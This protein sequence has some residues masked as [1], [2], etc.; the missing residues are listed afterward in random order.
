MPGFAVLA[1]LDLR[2]LLA[3]ANDPF[4]IADGWRMNG[5]PRIGYRFDVGGEPVEAGLTVSDAAIGVSLGERQAEM[6]EL[7]VTETPLG[8]RFDARIDGT[9][10]TVRCERVEGGLL[11]ASRGRITVFSEPQPDALADA[12]EAGGVV[13]APMPGKV[14]AV[15]VARG[16]SVAKG[17][18]LVVLE[19]MKMEH[20][21][22]APRDGVIAEVSVETGGQVSEGDILVTLAEDEDAAA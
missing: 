14:L 18:A 21:L 13:K 17:Q 12:A 5:E 15:N 20:A 2:P 16:D 3:S 6:S 1:A 11:V 8:Y 9:L 19:A 22:A 4:D 7:D 10:Q